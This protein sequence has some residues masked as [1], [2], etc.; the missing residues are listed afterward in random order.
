MR[1]NDIARYIWYLWRSIRYLNT[2]K[3][4]NQNKTG[5]WRFLNAFYT[6]TKRIMLQ[7]CEVIIIAA[8]I[9]E[10]NIHQIQD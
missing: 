6:K 7:S 9:V 8:N 1:Y 2:K 4:V 3:Y 5:L 10:S